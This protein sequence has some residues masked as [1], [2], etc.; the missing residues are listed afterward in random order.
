[1]IGAAIATVIGVAVLSSLGVWQLKRLA[2]KE[3]LI[4]EVSARVH[5]PPEEAPAAAAWAALR[6]DDYE[7]RHVRLRGVYDYA[8]QALVFRALGDPRGRFGGPGYLVMT[9]LK[10]DGGESV[11]VNR[12][13]VPEE[14]KADAAAGPRGETE[15]AGLMRSTEDR[16]WFTPADNPA[17]GEWFTRDIGELGPA[18]GLAAYA[19]FS[20]DADAGPD[21]AALPEGGETVLAFPNNHL[22]YA[23]TWFGMALALVGVFL[24]WVFTRGRTDG[25]ERSPSKPVSGGATPLRQGE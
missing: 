18:M 8:H 12:G 6:A 5:R 19:P 11:I 21:P 20:I 16:T 22:S 10:I 17:K 15:V 7:Y 13:F 2:W 14:R 1:L 3:G 4:A 23:F 9:P 25:G 24:A